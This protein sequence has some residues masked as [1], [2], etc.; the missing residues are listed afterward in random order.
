M[1]YS[2]EYTS[3]PPEVRDAIMKVFDSG[4]EVQFDVGSPARARSVRGQFYGY[5]RALDSAVYRKE[6]TQLERNVVMELAKAAGQ[7]TIFTEGTK[8]IIRLK[9]MTR[10]MQSLRSVLD[11]EDDP[12]GRSLEKLK[13]KL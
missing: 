9:S 1:S 4:Q 3:Y 7:V 11:E 2:K 12:A 8:V 13:E 5:K 6:L 10:E